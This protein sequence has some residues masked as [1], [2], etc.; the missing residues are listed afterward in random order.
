MHL[1]RSLDMYRDPSSLEYLVDILLLRNADSAQDDV[2]EKYNNVRVMCAKAIANHKNT[3][4]VSSLLYCLNN[5]NENYR[6]RLACA[7]ALGRI[8][9]RFAVAPLI[10]VVN[11]EDEKSVY[12]R[13]SAVSALG[14]LGDSRAIDPL[15]SILE[16]KQ[17]IMNKFSFL[18]ER[19]IEA[20]IKVGFLNNERV[21]RALKTSLSDESAQVRINAIEALMDSEHPKA[22][23]TIK[24]VLYEDSD[25]EVKK[26]AMIALYNMSDRSILDEVIASQDFS[27][28]LKVEAVSIIEEYEE[29]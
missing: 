28:D 23:E 11:D 21:F 7:D 4:V 22:F 13:E 16:T 12:L 27:D 20:L 9:D 8:G 1:I 5:K 18:K 25:I 24:H 29:E 14:L 15:V 2:R 26:N 19:A 6:V 3:D 17:G 10:D